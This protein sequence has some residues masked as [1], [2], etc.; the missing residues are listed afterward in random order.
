M[1]QMLL[2]GATIYKNIVQVGNAKN[3]QVFSQNII[4]KPLKNRESFSKF[5]KHH[6]E[7]VQ[8]KADP[9]GG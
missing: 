8:T 6:Q 3:I 2:S 7:L 4:Y 1:A 5:K 9:K